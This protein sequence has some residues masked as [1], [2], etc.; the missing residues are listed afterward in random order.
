MTHFPTESSC[1]SSV[2]YDS[3][4]QTLEV[5]FRHGGVY[6]YMDVPAT[7]FA[8]LVGSRSRGRYYHEHIRRAG[9]A[10]WKQLRP[11]ASER[12]LSA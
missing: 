4:T 7:V 2:G 5:R 1:F 3:D 8:G 11:N 9:Y 12:R 10:S 6:R